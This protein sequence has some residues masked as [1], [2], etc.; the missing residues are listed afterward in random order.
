MTGEPLA[1]GGVSLRMYPH[2]LPAADCVDEMRS[3]TRLAEEA[4]FDGV[5]TS[6]HHGGFRSYVPNPLQ[7]AGWLLD[8][9]TRLWAGPCPLLL[10]LRHWTHVAEELAWLAARFPGRVA[11]GFAVGGLERDF[12][13]A[14]LRFDEAGARFREALPLVSAALR[15]ESPPPLGDDPAI[16][17]C[18]QAPVPVVA[19]AQGPVGARRAGTLGLGVLYDSLQ[20]V[21][22]MREVSRAHAE[23]GSAGARIAI[24]RVWVGPPPGDAVAEQTRFYRSYAPGS[25]QAHWG[26]DEQL[27]HAAAPAE[28]ADRLAGVAQRG[29]CDAFNLRLHVHGVEPAA[30]RDQIGRVGEA[31][32]ALREALG[33]GSP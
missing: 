19:A 28:L 18:R 22:R 5:M 23:T 3:Q 20:T 32:P 12:E 2:D 6:E 13:M 8:A 31:L 30:I 4:G 14:E 21:D 25:A 24:R 29:E 7:L 1:P 15:G 26:D 9:T 33:G 11:A 16:A 27:V 10:P 17:A